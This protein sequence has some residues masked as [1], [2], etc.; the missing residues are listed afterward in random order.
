M[1]LEHFRTRAEFKV[2]GLIKTSLSQATA[3]GFYKTEIYSIKDYYD[4]EAASML[5]LKEYFRI[6]PVVTV[7]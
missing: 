5:L 6:C 7:L 1:Y 2:V 4:A 3:T